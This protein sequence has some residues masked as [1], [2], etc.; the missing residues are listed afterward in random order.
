ML[1]LLLRRW[2]LNRQ[3]RLRGGSLH[4]MNLLLKLLLKELILLKKLLCLS[5]TQPLLLIGRESAEL[6]PI[7]E[8]CV[9]RLRRGGRVCRCRCCRGG[10]FKA[11]ECYKCLKPTFLRRFAGHALYNV[12]VSAFIVFLQL[13][14]CFRFGKL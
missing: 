14:D 6:V 5:H 11:T 8:V 1:L 13:N 10:H 2:R 3:G 4:L 7:L 9:V 12:D